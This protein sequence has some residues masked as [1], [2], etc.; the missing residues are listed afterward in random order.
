MAMKNLSIHILAFAISMAICGACSN[1][2]DE[3][4]STQNVKVLTGINA[5]IYGTDA[6]ITR[7]SNTTEKEPIYV[8]R[9]AFVGGDKIVMTS[10]QRTDNPISDFT[11]NDIRWKKG[12]N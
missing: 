2:S 8:G 7:A 6:A 10:F 1:D 9:L 4:V 11:Y 3:N 12:G 5:D